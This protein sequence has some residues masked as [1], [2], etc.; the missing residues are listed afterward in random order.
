M[1]QNA[2]RNQA[3]WLPPPQTLLVSVRH[4][5]KQSPYDLS[6]STPSYYIR[7]VIHMEGP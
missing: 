3:Q 5:A 1:G 4:K 6:L 7:R 2:L